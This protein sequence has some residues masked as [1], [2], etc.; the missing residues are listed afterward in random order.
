MEERDDRKRLQT[1][2][3][4]NNIAM[5]TPSPANPNVRLLHTQFIPE[6]V[7]CLMLT[8]FLFIYGIVK[9]NKK[10]EDNCWKARLFTA[11]SAKENNVELT[12]NDVGTLKQQAPKA[13]MWG[14]GVKEAWELKLKRYQKETEELEFI[15]K[16]LRKTYRKFSFH[17]LDNNCRV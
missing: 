13:S 11:N 6:S 14:V 2:K 12:T 4:R 17:F 3:K 9:V 16:Q 8:S 1:Q 15:E 10:K 7:S 5:P